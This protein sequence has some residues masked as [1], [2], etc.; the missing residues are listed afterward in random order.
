MGVL[1][2]LR[3]FD[4]GFWEGI[5][6]F[7]DILAEVR[8]LVVLRDE[9]LLVVCNLVNERAVLMAMLTASSTTTSVGGNTI[10]DKLITFFANDFTKKTKTPLTVCSSNPSTADARA[11]AKLRL[12]VEH[13]KRTL[14]ASPGAATCS[15]ESLKDGVDFTGSINRMRFDMLVRPIY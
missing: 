3:G 5:D 15:V 13:T 10:D 12:A 8:E 7:D 11:E 14:S 6:M 1:E 4:H 2:D 9:L